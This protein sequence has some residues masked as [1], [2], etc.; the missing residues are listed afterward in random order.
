[1]Q[2]WNYMQMSSMRAHRQAAWQTPALVSAV[3]AFK[4]ASLCG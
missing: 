3:P 2:P 4:R 1:M